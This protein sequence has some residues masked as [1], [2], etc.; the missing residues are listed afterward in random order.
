MESF[1]KLSRIEHY[2]EMESRQGGETAQDLCTRC[3]DVCLKEF[4]QRCL[5]VEIQNNMTKLALLEVARRRTVSFYDTQGITMKETL[6]L[7]EWCEPKDAE[8]PRL[9]LFFTW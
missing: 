9:A 8:R 4:Q 6:K 1:K 3:S 5:A 7:A 2:G